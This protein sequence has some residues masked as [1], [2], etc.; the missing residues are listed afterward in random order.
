MYV[1]PTLPASI[2]SVAA[3]RAMDRCAI[4]RHG[5]EGLVLMQRAGNAAFR[6]ARRRFPAAARWQVVCGGGNNAGDG[7][8]VARRAIDAGLSV[9]VTSLVDPDRLEGDAALAFREY[10]EIGPPP[11]AFDGNLDPDADLVVD[12]LL[13]SGLERE[14]SGGFA[15]AVNAINAHT[16]AVVALDI[17]TGLHG[18]SGAVL[19]VAVR[20]DL[21]ITFVGLKAGLF[22]R[23]GAEYCGSREFAG[24]GI[25]DVCQAE[26]LPVLRRID[27]SMLAAALPP[28]RRTAHKGDFGHVVVIGGGAGMPGAV[29]LCGEAALRSGAGRVTVVTTPGQ[30]AAVVGD[31]PE[32]MC[33]GVATADEIDDL[34]D[35][36]D[37]VAIGPGLGTDDWAGA[38]FDAALDK[39]RA[40][41]L[42]ADALNLLAD[43][44]R[45]LRRAILTPHPGEAARLLATS[46]AVVQS[47][48][49]AA[50]AALAQRYDGVIVLKGAGTLVSAP[51][52]SPWL[53]SAGNPGM[54]APGMGDVLTGV[55]AALYAS[56]TPPAVAA[57]A[58]VEVHARAGDVAAR[59]GERGLLAGEVIAAL[60]GIVN[61]SRRL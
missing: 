39:A 23:D 25:P 42:D 56:G 27:D 44:P 41:V 47:D 29:R 6:A 51:G 8:V 38:L 14:V 57:A 10:R 24:L 36:A 7:Y 37:V 49:E 35:A 54:A 22:R 46:A 50:L 20:A 11:A 26:H 3:V 12:A 45:P 13:G 30:V 58:G 31:R 28:R 19:G 33:R 34:L 16:A 18:D 4:D 21:T 55:I 43:N 1:P 61:P 52:S 40:L 17:P 9:T 60:R 15:D 59:A 32:L 2:Y 48:R 5:I 53:C